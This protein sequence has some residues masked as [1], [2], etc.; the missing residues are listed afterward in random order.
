MA[1]PEVLS[2]KH[3]VDPR[4]GRQE[5]K[6]SDLTDPQSLSVSP[7]PLTQWLLY[8]LERA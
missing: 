6:G 3:G 2:A 1:V 5:L 8:S 4:E 7:S